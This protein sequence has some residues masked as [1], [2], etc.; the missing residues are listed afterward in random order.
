[1]TGRIPIAITAL[2]AAAALATPASAGET[3]TIEVGDDFYAP[4]KYNGS[5]GTDVHWLPD[6]GAGDQ[7]NV[8]ASG[9]LFK[10]GPLTDDI[11]FTISPSSG[12]FAYYC[13]EHGTKSGLGMAG[14]LKIPPRQAATKRGGDVIGVAWSDSS[15]DI[16]DQYDVRYKGPGTN[17]QYKTWLKNTDEEEGTFGEVD[18]PTDVKPGR[19]YSFQV[20]SEDSSEPSKRRSD[21]SPTLKVTAGTR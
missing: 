9:K 18:D 5:L 10:S 4:D 20:R 16:A 11:D 1:M 3:D 2:V 12:T 15:T 14:T 8:R 17:G 7:H 6:G 13:L 21:W 19:N